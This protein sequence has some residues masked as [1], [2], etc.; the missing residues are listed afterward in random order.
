MNKIQFQSGGLFMP[1]RAEDSRVR[2]TKRLLRQ[3]LTELL[4]EKSIKKITVRELSERVDINRGTFYLH[5]KDIYDLVECL[6][7]ELFEE[8][9]RIVSKF[10]IADL[11]TRPRQV[12]SDVCSFLYA[13]RDLC[14]ALLG[15]NG[16][17][18]FVLR[19]RSFLQ[20]KCMRDSLANFKTANSPEYKYIY[21]YFE[22]GAVGMMRYWLE[23][24]QDGKTPEQIASLIELL[25]TN[26]VNCFSDIL[27]TQTE[28]SQA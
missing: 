12:F 27:R 16:D 17:I 6:E 21:A 22:S 2:R 3:G 26:G 13:N 20:Q 1:T 19:L 14:A 10:T 15:D 9:E 7:N 8:F 23:N 25:F 4:Q 28:A 24:P 11:Q 18:N 5:Y